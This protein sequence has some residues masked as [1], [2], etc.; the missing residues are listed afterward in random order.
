MI[1]KDPT[2]I[3]ALVDAINGNHGTRYELLGKMERGVNGAWLLKSDGG[4]KH[5][6]KLVAPTDTTA[7]IKLTACCAEIVNGP[8]SRCPK[9]EQIGFTPDLGTWYIQEFLPGI[10]APWP[11]LELVSQLI[12]LNRRQEGRSLGE[13]Y[14]WSQTVREVLYADSR[15]WLQRIAAHSLEGAAL[16]HRVRSMLAAF[17]DF[18][19]SDRD[20]VH[21]D[22]QHYNALV[23]HDSEQ[24]TGYVDWDGAGFGDRAFDLARL[25]YDVYVGELECGYVIDPQTVAQLKTEIVKVSGRAGLC[26]YMAYWILQVADFGVQIGDTKKFFQTGNRILDELL[27]V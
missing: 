14:N 19:A 5:I 15:K 20:V 16:V 27:S 1:S 18:A 17:C 7:H 12:E 11:S 3:A 8:D 24:L 6:L 26:V 25:L 13:G 2:R 4:V 9:Y 23:A 21:G 10:P 22:F